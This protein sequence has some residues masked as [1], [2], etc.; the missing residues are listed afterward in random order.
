MFSHLILPCL[1]PSTKANALVTG[2]R[3][4][5]QN[6]NGKGGGVETY[7]TTL[8][9]DSVFDNCT[10]AVEGGAIFVGGGSTTVRRSTLKRNS[11]FNGGAIFVA[12]GSLTVED[13]TLEQNTAINTL[14]SG[15]VF[16]R[17]EAAVEA[18]G[19]TVAD[20]ALLAGDACSSAALTGYGLGVALVAVTSV[21]MLWV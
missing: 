13:S 2:E 18:C 11:A 17:G 16:S 1:S 4:R 8:I 3:R 14:G 20:D 6:A 21:W 19:N 10:A 7:G 5:L 15:N 12:D 9:E